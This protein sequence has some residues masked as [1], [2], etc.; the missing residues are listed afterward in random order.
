MGFRA[1]PKLFLRFLHQI[2]AKL[3]NSEAQIFLVFFG[4]FTASLISCGSSATS[5]AVTRTIGEL[6]DLRVRSAQLISPH[7]S[8]TVPPLT[9]AC[10][11]H[12]GSLRIRF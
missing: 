11:P 6:L 1:A 2:S 4:F 8:Y 3:R 9:T 12:F 7:P 5:L 10:V